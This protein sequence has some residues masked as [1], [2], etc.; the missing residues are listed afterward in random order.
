MTMAERI[1]I[2]PKRRDESDAFFMLGIVIIGLF[3]ALAVFGAVKFVG[4]FTH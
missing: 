3:A 4:M 1:Y 2:P